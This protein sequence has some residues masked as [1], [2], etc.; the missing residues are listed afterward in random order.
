MKKED[1]VS[2][3]LKENKKE[4]SITKL[5]ELCKQFQSERAYICEMNYVEFADMKKY[6]PSFTEE[7]IKGLDDEEIRKLFIDYYEKQVAVDLLT[8]MRVNEPKNEMLYKA[9]YWDQT[10][11]VRDIISDLLYSSYEEWKDNPVMVISTHVSKS[12]TLPVYHIYLKEYNT[13]II[14]RCNFYDWK[15]SIDT[16]YKITGI[17]DF[18]EEEKPI[19]PCY[20]EGFKVSQVFGMH[21]NNNKKFTIELPDDR[22]LVHT[23]FYVLKKSLNE[24][25]S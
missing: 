19:S 8:W 23:F 12:I 1:A 9:G 20:C 15:I 18:F 24:K 3:I 5:K 6:N 10:V 17:E 13:N 22:Y 14:M 21:K 11:F 2:L 4:I 7:S 25:I 16:P